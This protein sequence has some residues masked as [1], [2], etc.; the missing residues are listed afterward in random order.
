MTLQIGL[1]YAEDFVRQ[2][3]SSSPS[4]NNFEKP[5]IA[6]F[7]NPIHSPQKRAS[8]GKNESCDQGNNPE[9][10]TER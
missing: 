2:H 6:S 1:D 4:G 10:A 3:D 5:N 8:L 9:Q 7:Q